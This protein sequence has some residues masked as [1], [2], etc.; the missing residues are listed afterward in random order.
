[1]TCTCPPQ[2][3]HEGPGTPIL[4]PGV[5]HQRGCPEVQWLFNTQDR[6]AREHAEWHVRSGGILQS[7]GGQD[8]RRAL[9][10]VAELTRRVDLLASAMAD[11]YEILLDV[12]ARL[13]EEAGE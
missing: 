6:L 9:S 3:D 7:P 4:R 12:A 10:D 11:V 5:V 8:A 13:P 2:P 1:M